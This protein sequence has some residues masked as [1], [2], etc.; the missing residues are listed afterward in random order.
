[1]T[2]GKPAKKSEPAATEDAVRYSFSLP[3]G[4]AIALDKAASDLRQKTGELW[5]RAEVIR[6]ALLHFLAL[7]Q[8]K[9]AGVVRSVERL[10]RGPKL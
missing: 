3:P 5:H 4:E 6:A 9:Q 10:R 1:M 2:T 7:P 8:V